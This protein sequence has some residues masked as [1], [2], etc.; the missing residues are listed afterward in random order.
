MQIQINFGSVK[1]SEAI[2]QRVEDAVQRAFEHF[3]DRVTRVEV[4]LH[5]DNAKKAGP[6]DKRVVM[7]ARPA[8]FDPLA[9]E[10]GGDDLYKVIDETAGK[11]GRAVKNKLERAGAKA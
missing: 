11:L 3:A 8:G 6:H 10:H 2:E 4:H 1:N 9:V 5:D 7:E